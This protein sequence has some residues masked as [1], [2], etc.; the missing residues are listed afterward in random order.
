MTSTGDY[1][2]A[3]ELTD[4]ELKAFLREAGVARLATH[5]ADGSIHLA[6]LYFRYEDPDI[7]L[8]TQAVSRKVR[9]VE[10]DPR[11]TVLVDVTQPALVGVVVYGSARV[12]RENARDDGSG[13]RSRGPERR[14][15]VLSPA[16]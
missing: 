11:V 6:P 12:E 5:D 15:D 7:L 10:R 2:Q 8:G 14:T 4:D 9:N 16:H 3:P 1:P 13:V